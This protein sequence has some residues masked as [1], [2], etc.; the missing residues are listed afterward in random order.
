MTWAR[1]MQRRMQRV[2]QR[3]NLVEG[4]KT[5]S[6]YLFLSI[7]ISISVSIYLWQT[8]TKVSRAIQIGPLEVL[9]RRQM[10][11]SIVGVMEAKQ[12]Q[13]HRGR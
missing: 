12:N 9:K 1:E 2:S 11:D 3:V 7:N 13:N 6:L 4:K 10:E 5:I 8:M